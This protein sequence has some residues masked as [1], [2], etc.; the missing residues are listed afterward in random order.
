[1]LINER[2]SDPSLIVEIGDYTFNLNFPLEWQT[3]E[4]EAEIACSNCDWG[5]DC[6]KCTYYEYS[7]LF[8]LEQSA[9]GE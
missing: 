6:R 8:A 7:L 5:K 9:A 4:L 2:E 1:M 3:M